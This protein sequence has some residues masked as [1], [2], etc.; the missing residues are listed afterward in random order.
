MT[1]DV[2]NAVLVEQIATAAQEALEPKLWDYVVGGAGRE[3]TVARNRQAFDAWGFR[4]RVLRNIQ[5]VETSTS[6]LGEELAIPVFLS[7]IGSLELLHREGARASAQAAGQYGTTFFYGVNSATPMQDVVEAG[8]GQPIFQLYVRDGRDWWQPLLES[9]E[10]LGF[11]AL[12]ITVDVPVIGRRDRD[13]RN[14]FFALTASDTR[15]PNL[16]A[17]AGFSDPSRLH[18]LDWDVLKDIV[19]ATRLPVIVKGIQ[20]PADALLA[21]EAGAAA[22][23]VSNHG[24]RQLD[25]EPA[26]L[27]ILPGIVDAVQGRAKVL[28]DGGITR[29]IDVVKAL[30]LG[31]DAVGVGK[32]QALALAS[33]GAPGV[34]RLLQLFE[35]EIRN[36]LHQL[37]VASVG[38]LGRDALHP[39]S[40]IDRDRPWIA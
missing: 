24:G 11:R 1:N 25:D 19:A 36:T 12:C 21:V 38:A 4:R 2:E 26:T 8:R 23:Y 17:A 35:E 33:G 31:A 7:P 20:D 34:V 14:H 18:G 16:S 5:T 10:R 9:V 15:R 22:V 13:I 29:G 3:S 30:A 6:L 27:E 37:G 32:M 28:M 39:L 40:R